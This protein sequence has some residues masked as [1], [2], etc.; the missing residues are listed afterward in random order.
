MPA[1]PPPS[2]ARALAAGFRD[3]LSRPAPPGW[4]PATAAA[5]RDFAAAARSGAVGTKRTTAF[6]EFISEARVARDRWAAFAGRADELHGLLDRLASADTA[7]GPRALAFARGV[8]TEVRDLAAAA[9]SFEPASLIPADPGGRRARL[10]LAGARLAAWVAV[11]F[12]TLCGDAEPLVVAA[13]CRDTGELLC[14]GEGHADRS[15][16][17]LAGCRG[18]GD[19]AVRAAGNH[20]ER[21]DGGGPRAVRGDDLA[22]GDRLVGWADRFVAELSSSF[23]PTDD[24]AAAWRAAWDAAAANTYAAGRR[25]ELCL[26]TCAAG[27]EALGLDRGDQGA[28]DAAGLAPTGLAL[29]DLGRTRLRLDAPHALA[30]PHFAQSIVTA[31]EPVAAG[32]TR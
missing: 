5:A 30:A 9:G 24:P 19:A 29:T 22:A 7:A 13:A 1:V 21:V 15:A 12:R 25:G 14:A 3:L 20:H 26:R 32:A 27:L 11:Q 10:G 31:R 23:A 28:A 6:T 17:L 2:D 8:L 4:I 18:V 16:A